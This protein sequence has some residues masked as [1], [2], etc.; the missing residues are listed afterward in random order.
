MSYIYIYVCVCVC[1]CVCVSLFC[2]TDHPLFTVAGKSWRLCWVGHGLGK[3][4]CTDVRFGTFEI[5]I[6]TGPSNIRMDLGVKN[7]MI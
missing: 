6:W 3:T 1:V 7:F 4:K 5:L 2:Y